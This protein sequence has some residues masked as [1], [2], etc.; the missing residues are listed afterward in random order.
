M[1]KNKPNQRMN[2]IEKFSTFY[3]DITSMKIDDLEKIYRKDV[4]FID[5]I[6]HHQGLA[7]V[8][9]YFE[10]LL[11]SAKYCQ[12]DISKKL[13][14]GESDAT[15]CWTMSY[16]SSKLNG[17]TPIHVDGT[18]ILE[19]EDDMIVYHRDYYDLGQMVY[20]HLPLFGRLV[21]TIKRKMA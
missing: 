12:F 19:I 18:T 20:E 21:K 14:N 11:S 1:T 8:E 3:V 7:A 4:V 13:R 2:I 5:P 10:R 6:A 15:I 17:G 9:M 16:T